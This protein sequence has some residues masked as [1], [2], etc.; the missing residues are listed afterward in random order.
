MD[1]TTLHRAPALAKVLGVPENFV[2]SMKCAG[3]PM[4][5]YRATVAWALAWLKEHPDFSP[6]ASRRPKA[7][8]QD[9]QRLERQDGCRHR[10]P[11]P[12]VIR[13]RSA[14]EILIQSIGAAR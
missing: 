11:K 10:E 14:K 8:P 5:D 9:A 7:N 2:R 1:D 4:P 12:R 6:T 13:R 3:F